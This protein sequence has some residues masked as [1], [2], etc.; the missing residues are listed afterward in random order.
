MFSTVICPSCNRWTEL[1]DYE[2]IGDKEMIM[3]IDVFP[4]EERKEKVKELKKEFRNKDF[5]ELNKDWYEM[6]IE[7]SVRDLVKYLRNN[8]INTECSC[9]HEKNIQ[10]QYI[11]EGELMNLHRLLFTY[12]HEKNNGMKDIC[13]EIDVKIKVIEGHMYSTLNINLT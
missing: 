5:S 2:I 7:E 8:G 3:T 4:E 1:E 11:I 12:F 9:G 10:C 13:Y 6:N